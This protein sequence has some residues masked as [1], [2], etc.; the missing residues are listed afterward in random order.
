MRRVLSAAAQRGLSADARVTRATAGN[1]PK[2]ADGRTLWVSY[3]SPSV[4]RWRLTKLAQQVNEALEAHEPF[5]SSSALPSLV[6]PR[7]YEVRKG[8]WFLRFP[9]PQ[10]LGEV[11]QT[12]HGTNFETSCGTLTGRLRVDRGSEPRD[13]RCMLDQPR[14]APDPVAEWLRARFSAHGQVEDIKLARTLCNWDGGMAFVRF[15]TADHA[16]EALEALDGTPSVT[17]G[18]NMYLDFALQRPIYQLHPHPDEDPYAVRPV[19]PKRI[20]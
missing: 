8:Y 20:Q 19:P 3:T 9:E 11:Q 10:F 1:L 6:I 17:P 12:L 2:P 7:G 13:L 15:A 4:L 16:E 5:D 18:C 14:K